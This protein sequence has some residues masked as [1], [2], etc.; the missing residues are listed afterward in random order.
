M[1][2]SKVGIVFATPLGPVEVVE[3]IEEQI[4]KDGYAHV[5]ASR[6]P[7]TVMNAAAGMLSIL[8][9][10]K[11]PV[12]VISTNSGAIDGIQ[13][14]KEMM[15]N[16]HVDHVILVSAN[17]WTEFNMLW[18]Q[19]MAYDEQT[20][21][22]AD[23]CSAQILSRKAQE[24]EAVILGSRQ[25]K[26]GGKSLEEVKAIFD[27]AFTELLSDLALTKT[28]IKACIWNSRKKI[29]ST[30][31]DFL[32]GLADVYGYQNLAEGQF[33]FASN[34]AGEELD[35]VVNEDLG[36]GHYLVLSYSKFGG[37]S[38]AIVKK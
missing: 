21:I 18:W 30:D 11:G 31:Y 32:S 16:D 13:Y 17:Q 14:A 20:F 38:F 35:F 36:S 29:A 34:G 3:G 33:A 23:Y 6:F 37:I 8:F 7:F 1:D 15:R 22:G 26:Y 4:T 12:S 24:N 19:Q 5:S 10:I 9:K 27:A 25:L 2:T 28:D